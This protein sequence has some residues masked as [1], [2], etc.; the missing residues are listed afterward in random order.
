MSQMLG[1]TLAKQYELHK[2]QRFALKFNAK[3]NYYVRYVKRNIK[4]YALQKLLV[5]SRL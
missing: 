3:F 4:N 1:I 2:S 5:L